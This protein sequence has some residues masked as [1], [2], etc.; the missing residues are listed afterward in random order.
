MLRLNMRAEREHEG[1]DPQGP[2]RRIIDFS[3]SKVVRP[4]DI[5]PGNSFTK[6]DDTSIDFF[7]LRLRAIMQERAFPRTA[8]LKAIS[9]KAQTP[10]E[11]LKNTAREK[12]FNGVLKGYEITILPTDLSMAPKNIYREHIIVEHAV[13]FMTE[14]GKY[15]SGKGYMG[16]IGT[17]STIYFAHGNRSGAAGTGMVTRP[18]TDGAVIAVRESLGIRPTV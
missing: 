18:L 3:E 2:A 1:L 6:I 7:I 14:V 13:T 4:E 11:I 16:T 15:T 12:R 17:K 9:Y 10:K 8:P 5:I